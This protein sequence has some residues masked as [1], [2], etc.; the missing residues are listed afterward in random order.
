MAWNCKTCG[1]CYHEETWKC[2]RCEVTG[3]EGERI[4]TYYVGKT[5]SLVFYDEVSPFGFVW[6]QIVVPGK[7]W[8]SPIQLTAS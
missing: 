7:F 4:K 5:T 3:K 1:S 6:S 2:V 8:N